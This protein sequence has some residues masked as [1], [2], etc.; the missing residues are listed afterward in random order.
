MPKVYKRRLL[1]K[2]FIRRLGNVLSTISV[3]MII[4]INTVSAATRLT[5][6]HLYLW[7]K[8]ANVTRLE[9]YKRYINIK[10]YTTQNTALCIAQQQKDYSAYKLLLQFGASIHVPCHD[11]SDLQCRKIIKEVGG[12]DAG[13]LVLGAAAIGGGAL[14]L[15]GGGGGGSS[16]P[17][18]RMTVQQA[19]T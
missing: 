3:V 16:G 17:S 10:D 1:L 19:N 18:C 15:G 13:L 8:N 14:A 11:N 4:N 7:A 12:I 5:P 2:R 6:Y 9:E